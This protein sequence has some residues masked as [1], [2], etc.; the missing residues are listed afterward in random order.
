MGM[1]S[2]MTTS[3]T[4]LQTI[5]DD[6]K[7]ARVMAFYLLA[8]FGTVPIGNLMLGAIAN[9]AGVPTTL[10]LAGIASIT[11]SIFF[12]VRFSPLEKGEMKN[13]FSPL[14][15]APNKITGNQSL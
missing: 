1:T 8:F 12:V 4:F 2:Q 7:R 13:D 11:G 6:S 5:C 10:L 14:P 9:W 3:N 15:T